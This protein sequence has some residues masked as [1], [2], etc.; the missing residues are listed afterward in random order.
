[1]DAVEGHCLAE[2]EARDAC[3][4]DLGQSTVSW[5][6]WEGHLPRRVAAGRVRVANKLRRELDGVDVALG[7]GRISFEH[8]RVLADAANPRVAAQIAMVQDD[9]VA[10]VQSSP[11]G[12][13]QR[14]VAEL[15]ELADQDGGHDPQQDLARNRLHADRV[16]D[17]VEIRGQLVGEAALSFAQALDQATDALFLRYKADHD[18]CP[19]IV[20]PARRCCEPWRWS[21]C[22]ATA[23]PLPGPP[24]WSMS[25]S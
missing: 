15:V 7:D 16:G 14:G 17:T 19:D 22:A 11:F 12:A 2:L 10:S 23:W 25:P 9:L 20:I 8:A 1:L 4:V 13:W 21:S 18:A 24:P 3:D 6:T 5:L